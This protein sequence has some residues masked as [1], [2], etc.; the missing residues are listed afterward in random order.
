MSQIYEWITKDSISADLEAG[1]KEKIIE[2]LVKLL[3]NTKRVIDS[4]LVET[5]I[6]Q[7]ENV[8]STQISPQ[9]TV[10][11]A[12]TEGVSDFC[13]SLGIVNKK[14]IFMLIA[15]NNMEYKNLKTLAKLIECVNDDLVKSAILS[16]RDSGEIYDII[17][18][19]LS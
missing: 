7:R 1:S 19:A 2:N 5:D 11:H 17:T 10:P 8:A 6:L 13:V 15:W 12:H 9:L 3:K 16:A 4:S 18:D 14:E